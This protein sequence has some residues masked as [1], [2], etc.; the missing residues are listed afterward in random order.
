MVL[1]VYAKCQIYIIGKWNY[2][3]FLLTCCS[4]D[5]STP[6]SLSL[7]QPATVPNSPKHTYVRMCHKTDIKNSVLEFDKLII[8][9]L[10]ITNGS[11]Y[12]GSNIF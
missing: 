7:P 2:F 9:V 4:I 8:K 10:A 12:L 11:N 5:G 1:F 3:V 6:P